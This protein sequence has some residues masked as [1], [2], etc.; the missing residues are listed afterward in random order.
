M[1]KKQIKKFRKHLSKYLE[2]IRAEA[3][4]D[5]FFLS[6]PKCGRTWVRI[7]L[8]RVFQQHFDLQDPKLEEL[9]LQLDKLYLLNREV[10]RIHLN[11][12][13]WPHW[14]RPEELVPRKTAYRGRNVIRPVR[15]PVAR[16]RAPRRQDP[17]ERGR[18]DEPARL[19]AGR[20]R[21]ITGTHGR[22]RK[23]LRPSTSSPQPDRE[24]GGLGPPG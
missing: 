10:P 19:A 22:R 1:R 7:M 4:A 5:A 16:C 11:H 12:D 18:H 21:L 2:K 13:G 24:P 6:L 23:K 3:S 8:G 17:L 15:D 9:L 14:K 20:L